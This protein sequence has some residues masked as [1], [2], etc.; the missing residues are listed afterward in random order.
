[1]DGQGFPKAD[2]LLKRSEFVRLTRSGHRTQNQAFIAAWQKTSTDR[3]R[4]GVTV[5]KKVGGAVVRNRIKR[6]ARETFR[7]NKN[8]LGTGYDVNLIAKKSAARLPN[9]EL[10]RAVGE[11]LGSIRKM[12]GK[13][14]AGP[15]A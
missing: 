9:Q 13:T 7:T 11:I 15:S 1:M 3:S 14:S 10:S 8:L 5:S 4:L 12:G 2:R 6:I